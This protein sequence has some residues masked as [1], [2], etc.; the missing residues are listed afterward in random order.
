[1]SDESESHPL[2]NHTSLITHHSMLSETFGFIGGG[3]IARSLIGG[4]LTHGL[5]ARQVVV[6]DPV[7]T[8]RE[9]LTTQ[10]GVRATEDNLIAARAAQV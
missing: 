7:A 9:M 6:S 1:M 4:L 3:N 8:Q 2:A 5:P 10:L